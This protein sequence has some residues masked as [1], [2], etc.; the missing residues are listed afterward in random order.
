M[1]QLS[2]I[3]PHQHDDLRLESTIL[4]VLENRPADSEVIVVHDG[5]YS[6]PYQLSDELLYVE[7]GRSRGVLAQLNAGVMAACAPVVCTLLDGVYV[8]QGWADASLDALKS[9]EQISVVAVTANS[10]EDRKSTYG[11]DG[12]ALASLNFLQ[13]GRVDLTRPSRTCLGP[14]LTCGFY[15]TKVIRAIGGWNEKLAL[16]VADIDMAWML[17]ALELQCVN[18]DDQ[19]TVSPER[20][21]SFDNRSMKQLAELAVAYGVSRGGTSVA[22]SDLLRVCLSGHVSQAVAWASGIMSARATE[23]VAVRLEQAQARLL[24]QTPALRVFPQDESRYRRQA[25]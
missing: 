23:S 10:S 4:S 2:I 13:R 17:Q 22:M 21:R 8:S 3:I 7:I 14:E 19:V 1:P 16:A 15:R 6:D 5:S 18:S 12:R 11:I 9:D 20:T 25:A 24:E